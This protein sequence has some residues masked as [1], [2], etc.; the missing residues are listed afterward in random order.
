MGWVDEFKEER[1]DKNRLKN[2]QGE[3]VATLN[4]GNYRNIT[5]KRRE[6]KELS[7]RN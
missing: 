6:G 2:L 5:K 4:K 7:T 1:S 3:G